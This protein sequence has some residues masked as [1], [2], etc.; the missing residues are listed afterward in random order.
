[1]TQL[2]SVPKAPPGLTSRRPG[3]PKNL[4]ELLE[5][6]LTQDTRLIEVHLSA[7]SGI[8]DRK[9]LVHRLSGSEGINE[10]FRYEVECL[11]SDAFISLK[12]LEGLSAQV[13]LRTASGALRTINGVILKAGSEGTDGSLAAYRLVLE[14]ATA[15]LKL[16]RTSRVF[17]GKTDLEVVLL[18]LR[19]EIQANAVFAACLSLDNRC[20]GTFPTREFIFLCNENSSWM[21]RK[22]SCCV[23]AAPSWS[24]RAAASAAEALEPGSASTGA[25]PG[26]VP[27]ARR[28]RRGCSGRR[29]RKPTSS[30]ASCRM[31][32]P[33]RGS[34]MKS[35]SKAARW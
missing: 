7:D 8:P 33:C 21:R 11:S 12:D 2:G 32:T 35:C 30:S 17:L 25:S 18:L 23:P 22:A 31:A 26:Q 20:R 14:P 4:E 16:G 27:P 5:G 1:M 24:S 19:E 34:A 9:L 15:A 13:T 3:F 28:R 6:T 10:G 29:A